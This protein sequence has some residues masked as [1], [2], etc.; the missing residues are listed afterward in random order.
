MHR[1]Y[2]TRPASLAHLSVPDACVRRRRQSTVYVTMNPAGGAGSR[3]ER[4]QLKSAHLQAE[5]PLTRAQSDSKRAALH[6]QLTYANGQSQQSNFQ[7]YRIL[8]LNEMPQ[9]EVYIVASSTEPLGVGEAGVPP[10]APA[11]ANA[12]FAATGKRLR[13]LPLKLP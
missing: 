5:V 3:L 11:V 13:E 6:E 8:R 12:V 10:I 7:G 1:S 2:Q 9:I 4:N